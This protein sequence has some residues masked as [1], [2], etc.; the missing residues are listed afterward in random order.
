[1]F[2]RRRN[3][4]E[5]P[6]PEGAAATTWSERDKARLQKLIDPLHNGFRKQAFGCLTS[7]GST[8]LCTPPSEVYE[9]LF[10]I[11]SNISV[12]SGL[13]LS[14]LAGSALNPLDPKRFSTDKQNIAEAFNVVAAIAACIQ[15]CVVLYSTFTLYILISAAHNSTAV[16]RALTHMTKWI[17]FIEFCT[18]VPALLFVC[19]II[20]ATKLYCDAFATWIVLGVCCGV[21][22]VFQSFFC[23]MCM[24]AFPVNA[25]NWSMVFGGVQWL[26]KNLQIDAKNHGKILLAQAEEGVLGGLDEDGDGVI[27]TEAGEIH[28]STAAGEA[29]LTLWV[30]GV[31]DLTPTGCSLL[32]KALLVAGLTRARII[33]AA[34]HAGGFQALCEMLAIEQFELRSGDRLALASAAMSDSVRERDSRSAST[35]LLPNPPTDA[36]RPAGPAF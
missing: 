18:F 6:G 16:Y 4:V 29:E 33:E 31:L 21:V 26:S 11:L 32:V 36:M 17:G 5:G 15:L 24:G 19:L 2:R 7:E 14:S 27:D 12:V 25:W 10:S 8:L 9:R 20:L 13:V 1:M 3:R 35:A 28:N 22:V 34:R 30:Q 23:V